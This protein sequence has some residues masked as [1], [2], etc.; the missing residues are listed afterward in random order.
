M[1][2]MS[3]INDNPERNLI[4]TIGMAIPIVG[5][6]TSNIIPLWVMK[7]CSEMPVTVWG[8]RDEM[9]FPIW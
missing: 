9:A 3:L 1:E 6:R 7:V 4:T 5:P 8:M 2:Q